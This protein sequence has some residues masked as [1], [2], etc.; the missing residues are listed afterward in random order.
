MGLARL[1]LV[2]APG[3]VRD[4]PAG[5][6]RGCRHR[7]HAARPAGRR[8]AGRGRG[9]DPARGR[10]PCLRQ[11]ERDGGHG[12]AGPL[13]RLG[14]R[15]RGVALAGRRERPPADGRTPRRGPRAA[16]GWWFVPFANS[17]VPYQI[18]ADAVRRLRPDR[19]DGTERLLLP[20][21]IVWV[22]ASL[23]GGV[24]WRLPS[25]TLEALRQTFILTAVSDWGER[26]RRD[27]AGLPH[28]GDGTPRRRPRPGP[29]ARPQRAARL[30][31]GEDV[32]EPGRAAAQPLR[33][34]RSTR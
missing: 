2:V 34:V 25:D 15:R 4:R 28:P 5:G 20:W 32:C 1:S 17:V 9:R 27:P 13:P 24:L 11:L 7:R 22:A 3:E 23:V 8:P 19:D 14:G 31:A 30:A 29:G 12:A 16:I 10:C 18:T 33:H 21:W 6:R 26:R